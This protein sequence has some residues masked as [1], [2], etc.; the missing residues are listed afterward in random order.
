M[1][2]DAPSEIRVLAEGLKSF[3][4]ERLPPGVDFVFQFSKQGE[5]IILGGNLAERLSELLLHMGWRRKPVTRADRL[6][7]AIHYAL[8]TIGTAP[9][10]CDGCGP[11]TAERKAVIETLAGAVREEG[12]APGRD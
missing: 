12:T 2:Q 7:K 8:Q 6:E 10:A 3:V 1:L 4:A 9:C 5:W 11:C